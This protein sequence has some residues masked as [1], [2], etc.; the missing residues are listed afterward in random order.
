MAK[1]ISRKITLYIDG[2]QVDNTVKGIRAEIKKLENQQRKAT[3]GSEEYLKA[4]EKIAQLK[5]IL[6][7]QNKLVRD[8]GETWK[9]SA[10]KAA[11]HAQILSGAKAGIDMAAG[12]YSR[13]TG[14][15]REYV[16]EA[17]AMDDAMA[18][19]MKTTGLTHEEVER[20]NEGLKGLKTR[21]S[22][23]ELNRLAS[24][25]GKLGI[26]GVESVE[27]FVAA[28]DQI[29]VALGEDLGEGAMVTPGGK[30]R[31]GSEVKYGVAAAE[32]A[33]RCF[34]ERP[35]TGNALGIFE[36][37]AGYVCLVEIG[38]VK[39]GT[40]KVGVGKVGVRQI[41]IREVGTCQ[42]GSD[43]GRVG[44]SCAGKIRTRQHRA[45][46]AGVFKVGSAK[47]GARQFLVGITSLKGF[48]CVGVGEYDPAFF[49]A[50]FNHCIIRCSLQK[51]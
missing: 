23:E 47:V 40:R 25:A 44:K 10:D 50:D 9:N 45:V 51:Y 16:E 41:S 35:G 22:R 8:M 33:A 14:A 3:I 17:A 24:E 12:A 32:T 34:A 48:P 42:V 31:P 18:D 1:Q 28:A 20:L 4:T 49:V 29:G 7:E 13:V 43:K 2:T 26:T 36:T 38:A 27:S 37:S 46:K 39:P 5:S 15:M 6:E 19:V 11:L 21:T 30:P